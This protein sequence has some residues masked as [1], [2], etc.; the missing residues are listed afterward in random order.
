VINRK[1][2]EKKRRTKGKEERTMI[3]AKPRQRKKING[4]EKQK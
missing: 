4:Q 3:V 2:D 1:D